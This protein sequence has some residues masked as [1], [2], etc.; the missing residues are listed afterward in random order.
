[1]LEVMTTNVTKC[2]PGQEPAM[3]KSKL[4]GM[5]SNSV[6]EGRGKKLK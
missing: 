6:V 3:R 5:Q 4:T 1:M 2:Q